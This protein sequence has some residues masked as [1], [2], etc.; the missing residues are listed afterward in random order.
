M[1]DTQPSLSYRD[2]GVNIDAADE[3]L[4]NIKDLVRRT[5]DDNVLQD[6]GSFGAMYNF[7]MPDM[8]APV[9]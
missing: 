6:L 7:S 4:H 3:A 2:A 5:F 9:Q 8:E 1:D